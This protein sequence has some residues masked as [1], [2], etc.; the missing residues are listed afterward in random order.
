MQHKEIDYFDGS[1]LLKGLLIS[2]ESAGEEKKPAIIVFHAFEGRG[3]F[4]IKYAEKLAS[5]GYITF[6]ADMYGN[7]QVGTTISECFDLIT[8]FLQSRE[9]VRRRA[10]LA[11][12]TLLKQ[13]NINPQKIGAV[14]FC[15][16]GMCMFELARSGANLAAGVSMHGV[17]A[18]SELPTHEIKSSLLVL[19]GYQDPQIPPQQLHAFGDEMQAAKVQ[20][21]TLTFFGDAKHSFTDPKTGTFDPE[22]EAEMGREYNAHAASRS[23]R[24]AVEF[25]KG[26][27]S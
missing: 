14:G 4:T 19:H 1:V 11:Y 6:V 27:L 2:T 12:K 7:A 9:L 24:M 3:E 5:E 25:F 10:I 20:D 26:Q 16:G 13:E 18:K 22:K 21:W 23:Y 15:F 8:P 17:L